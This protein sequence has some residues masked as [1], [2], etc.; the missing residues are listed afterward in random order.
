MKIVYRAVNIILAILII[1]SAVF[2]NFIEVRIETTSSLAEIFK[3]FSKDAAEGAALYEDFSV[4]RMVDVATGK[5]DLSV[6]FRDG[7]PILWPEEFKPLNA[8]LITVGVCFA[9]IVLIAV[10][11]LVFSIISKKSL[12]VFIAGFFGIAAD[13]VMMVCFRSVSNDV[14][15]KKVDMFNFLVD[16]I[17]GT[18]ILVNLVGSLASG[19]FKIVLALNGV[20]NAFL[21]LMMAVILWAAIFFL[22]DLGDPKAAEMRKAEKELKAKKK[23]EKAAKK[24]AK[25][26]AG[27][28][29]QAGEQGA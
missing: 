28:E 2:V 18:G 11:I 3:T 7:G 8:R 27:S 26:E 24:S 21:F 9:L 6:M 23:A 13:I 12:P 4:K 15:D 14:Y 25:K 20:Q 16:R 5:D 1:L 10:F 22:V 29:S 17:F 19:A